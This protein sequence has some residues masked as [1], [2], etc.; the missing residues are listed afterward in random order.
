MNLKPILAAAMILAAT[1]AL[2]H[3]CPAVMAEIDAAL[4]SA[5]LTDEQRAEVE[6]LRA[7]GEELHAAGNHDA[8]IEALEEAKAI[9]GL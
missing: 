8:S 4:P 2:A 5:T 6:R 3:M 1:P 7:E 9:M